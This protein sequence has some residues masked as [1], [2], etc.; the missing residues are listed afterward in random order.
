MKSL[1]KNFFLG[2]CIG[3][4]I[5]VYSVILIDIFLGDI[6]KEMYSE[7][8]LFFVTTIWLAIFIGIGLTF[9]EKNKNMQKEKRE[10]ILTSSIKVISTLII[11]SIISLIVCIFIKYLLGGFI[12]ILFAVSLS[13]W[14]IG[15]VLGYKSLEK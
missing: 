11:I 7:Y 2:I 10:I 5:F 12:S 6:T 1:I 4:T 14:L 3:T 15:A 13:F 8:I 9:A